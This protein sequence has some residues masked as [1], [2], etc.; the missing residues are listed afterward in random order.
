VLQNLLGVWISCRC[1]QQNRCCWERII[2]CSSY[3]LATLMYNGC[4]KYW[5]RFSKGT[6]SADP[7]NQYTV[8]F[9]TLSWGGSILLDWW[10]F[11]I[12]NLPQVLLLVHIFR[13]IEKG[14]KTTQKMK[15][16]VTPRLQTWKRVGWLCPCKMVRVQCESW[17][18][19]SIPSHVLIFTDSPDYNTHFQLW[20]R[21]SEHYYTY[22]SSSL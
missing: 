9:C 15:Q 13:H 11:I 10:I 21:K 22:P 12:N 8:L 2:K 20:N 6:R 3:F 1:C 16:Q 4:T 18:R 5:I 14:L 19:S 7:N 17:V